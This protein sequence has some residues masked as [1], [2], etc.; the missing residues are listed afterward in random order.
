MF[1]ITETTKFQIK[2]AALLSSLFLALFSL[3]FYV[4]NI[5]ELKSVVK[6]T[7][8]PV[9]PVDTVMSDE[10][11]KRINDDGIDVAEFQKWAK[12][13]KLSGK[14]VYDGD[15]DAD[16][17]ANYLEFMHGTDPNKA[18]TDGDTFTDKQEIANGYDPAA[19]GDAKPLVF[20]KIEKIGVD[21]PMIW[22][23]SEDQQQAL[24]DLKNGLSHFPKS[25][26]PGE[27][28]N[29]IIS[30]H[31]SNYVWAK[32]DFNYVFKQL[33]NL[34]KGDIVNIKTIQKNGKII[35]FKYV[36]GEKFV[37]TPDDERIFVETEN[38]TLTLSTC[39][40]LGTNLKRLIVKGELVK[41]SLNIKF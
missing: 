41:T 37:T 4:V 1:N 25:A 3:G 5:V 40:P 11:K 16:G 15:A 38:P 29:T 36:I 12:D 39:W 28:G 7:V 9:I 31:S 24:E 30:G 17:L 13:N 18:D 22:S 2:K 10:L 6:T 19:P 26:A 14:N 34:E 8:K 32:G 35:Y 27:K 21:V 20:V 33:N 23:Q